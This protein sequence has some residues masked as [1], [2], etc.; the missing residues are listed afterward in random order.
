[1]ACNLIA[2]LGMINFTATT[3]AL[4]QLLVADDH[5]GRVM[6]LHTVMFMGTSPIGSLLMGGLAQR[7]GPIA[8]LA[9]SG[10]V[11]LLAA[12]WLSKRL[13]LAALEQRASA[14]G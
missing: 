14:R 3:N 5:R 12:L 4:L 7:F 13:P 2:G 8:A 10:S 11:P 9:V 1:M 6:G